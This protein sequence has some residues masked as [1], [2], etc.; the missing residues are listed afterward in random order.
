MH[1]LFPRHRNVFSA[2][3]A[4]CLLGQPLL[5]SAQATSVYSYQVPLEGTDQAIAQGQLAFSPATHDFGVLVLGSAA[6]VNTTLRNTGQ[7]AV[8][9]TG[10]AVPAPF[11]QAN[12]CPATLVG[13]ASCSVTVTYDPQAAGAHSASLAVATADAAADANFPVTGSAVVPTTNLTLSDN[14]ID[15]GAADVGANAPNKTLTITNAGNSPA[16]VNGI[17]ITGST[18]FNQSNNCGGKLA[19]GAK[20]TITLA[21]VPNAYG[22]RSGNLNVFEEAS[23]TL[24]SVALSGHGDAA[25]MVL[26]PASLNLGSAVANY[27]S[28]SAQVTVSNT[29]NQPLE[30][31]S[32]AT[33]LADYSISAKTCTSTLAAGASCNATVQFA[34]A[35]AGSRVG[36]FT[37]HAVDGNSADVALSGTGI[38][39]APATGASKT[40]LAFGNIPV[41][42]SSAA[43]QVTFTNTGNVPVS[44]SG[45]TFTAGATHYAASSTCG[46]SLAVGATCTASV[47]FS[48]RAA[49]AQPGNLRV[50]FSSGAH[51]IALSGSGTLG[52]ASVSPSSLSFADQQVAS[53]SAAKT[54]TVTNSGNRKLTFASVG[55]AT[56]TEHFAQSNTCAEVAPA[57]TCTVSVTFT[58][59]AAG[60]QTG[61]LA[62]THDGVDGTTLVDL[63]GV[64]RA[65]S[66]ALGAV[67]F[68][69][70]PVG[71][72]STATATLSNTGIGALSVT[73]PGASS[74][75]GTGYSFVSTTCT[76]SLAANGSC[77]VTVRFAPTSTAPA[78][79]T[80]SIAT[81]AGNQS[82]SFGSTGIQGY[83]SISP[84]SLTFAA[85]QTNTTSGAQT[86]TV[87]NTGTDTL[88]FSSVGIATGSAHFGQANG[89]ASVPVGGTCSASV[90]FTPTATGPLTGTL[91]FTHN[92]GGIAL[93]D[94]SGTGQAPSATLG[95]LNFGNVNAGSSATLNATLTNTGIAPI[96]VTA[97]S[98]AS[99]TGTGF[100][101]VST[102]CGTQLAAGGTC[103]TSVRFA[104]TA[105]GAYT[106]SLAIATGA[107]TKSASLAGNGSQAVLSFS[108]E[109][110]GTTVHWGNK[111]VG[112]AYNS[113]T[114]TLANSGNLAATGLS[115]TPSAP[116]T[117]TSNTCSSS[118]AAGASCTFLM[119]FN[120]TAVQAYSGAVTASAAVSSVTNQ[121]NMT[122]SG[123]AQSATLSTPSFA[124][125]PVGSSSTAT[126]TLANTGVGPLAV[127][128]PSAASVTGA[129]YS[130]ASTT[131]TNSLAASSSCAIVVRFSPSATGSAS[132][133]LTVGTG[134]G[135]KAVS[136][137]STGIQGYASVSPS[138]LTF[139]TYGM[140][141]TSPVQTVTVTN[142]GSDTLTFTGVGISSGSADFAQS[143]NCGAVAVGG[144]CTVNVT[145]SPS[146]GGARSGTLSFTHNGGGIANVSLSGTGQ[147]PSAS[148]SMGSFPATQVGSSSTAVAT[149]TNTGIGPMPVAPPG[150]GSVT[151]DSAFSFVSTTC[152]STLAVGSNCTTTIRFSPTTR[153]AVTGNF[154]I[155]DYNQWHNATLSATGIQGAVSLSPGSLAFPNETANR[156]SSTLT[157]TVTNSGN[158]TL[159]VSSMTLSS[160][161]PDFTLV[162]TNCV[163][164][165]GPGGTCTASV[166]FAPTSAGAKN[167][168][169]AFAHNGAGPTSF[170]L[171]GTGY[172]PAA[173]T[174]MSFSPAT[175]T[176]GNTSTFSWSTSNASSASVS[177]SGT[178]AGSKSGTSGSLVVATSGTGTGT[179]TVTA[180]NV[181]GTNSSDAASLSVVA[182]PSAS[183]S[184]SPT[185]VT[186]GNSSTFSWSTSNA[187]SAS[188]ACSGAASG[189]GSGLSGSI[190]VGTS[191]AGTGTCTVTASNAAGSQAASS[192]NLTV[193]P[194]YSYSWDSSGWSTPSA[195][196]STTATRSVWCERSDGATV[197]DAYCG[198]AKPAASTS[199]TDYSACT[200]SWDTSGWDTPSACGTTTATRSVW[201]ERSDGTSVSDAYCS[202]TKPSSS[203]STT[204]YTGCTYSWASGS[205][206]TPSGCGSVTQT[207]SVWCQRSD[208]ATASDGYCS[209]TKPSTTQ[210]GTNYDSCTYTANL[211]SWSSCSNSCGTGTQTRSVSCTR[212]DGTTVSNTYCGSPATSQSCS[213]MSGCPKPSASGWFNKSSVTS[214]GTASF[215]WS[216]SGATISTNVDCWGTASGSY[217]G[218]NASG[219]ITVYTSGTGTGY[220]NVAAINEAG[221]TDGW[222]TIEVTSATPPALSTDVMFEQPYQEDYFEYVC[223]GSAPAGNGYP[224]FNERVVLDSCNSSS[225]LC[226]QD[227]YSKE[228]SLS[229]QCRNYMQ[230]TRGY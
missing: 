46:A 195:C 158:T 8:A 147:H 35:A 192:A 71:S 28:T 31:L 43:Q 4:L 56:G 229:T 62:L 36:A 72:T 186:A 94:L 52:V 183:S 53:T 132:G 163:G 10:F 153:N 65:Q 77:T 149:F 182:A 116:W 161:S 225:Y 176:S 2:L 189:S 30:G 13:G 17:G 164:Q 121:M 214:G 185:T 69:A 142:T 78:S 188:V 199:T 119:T 167:G 127:T 18:E 109:L 76:S 32:L 218:K 129:G 197:S 209:G 159:T 44:Y 54:V 110:G 213:N 104:P 221:Q 220:C 138:S 16:T 120:P 22:T 107:G 88:T 58:P 122:G 113:A 169:I 160:G 96:T 202:G 80:L 155:A 47:T 216:T 141:T 144:T 55:I 175:V 102:T 40:S 200:Y 226:Q 157:M 79:G 49:G 20:C 187:T 134:A 91:A 203:T 93:V 68:P 39:Q 38:A 154:A 50:T 87:T 115:V 75:T 152:G 224:A 81:G 97:P 133:T 206:S 99:V 21:F 190:A 178:A 26:S 106:G 23:G 194:A 15:F 205:W 227:F 42:G 162:S 12:T 191:A 64:G 173:I 41:D 45:L 222:A 196:G 151:G 95:G 100:S 201:C 156:S 193:N 181:L 130:F 11:S 124:P 83:A 92:G 211:G 145:F 184:F 123:V 208:G 63:A 126:A 174:S 66:A 215:S 70:T 89:C 3:T 166:R 228:A 125:T 131:C 212:S 86:V 146:G 180:A 148:L 177:C 29:G 101:F 117:L 27:G 19:P 103:T 112:G 165:M 24:Y 111:Q 198:G 137:G 1:A 82:V 61:T 128:V 67:T 60:A 7:D 143:N 150:P 14:T 33:T 170:A 98:A 135:S 105:G 210:G 136:L 118:L 74:V 114:V 37:A 108:Y 219:S 223:Y 207:R 9:I 6:T 73:V 59:A 57:G 139:G 25:V 34:P 140:W 5:A 172:A 171:S 217:R 51:N 90:T 48:P 84:S 85:Q 230:S 179:C 168:S 204:S